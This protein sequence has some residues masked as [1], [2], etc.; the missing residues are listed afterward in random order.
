MDSRKLIR[1]KLKDHEKPITFTSFPRLGVTDRPFL[2]PHYDAK[3]PASQSLFLP[4]ELINPH[5]RFP[6][7]VFFVLWFSS[8]RQTY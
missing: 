2:D 8:G 6:Y 1:Q 4:D 5:I 7:D 3:G